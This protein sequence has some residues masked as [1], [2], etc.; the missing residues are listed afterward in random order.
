MVRAVLPETFPA[1]TFIADYSV[2]TVE[3]AAFVTEKFNLVFFLYVHFTEPV[4]TSVKSEIRYGKEKI[5]AV[6]FP[7]KLIKIGNYLCCGGYKIK[8]RKILFQIIKQKV[9]MYDDAVLHPLVCV[10]HS[11]K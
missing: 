9:R 3:T 7:D 4:K 2:R 6:R 11:A 5:I 10:K 1:D 8:S